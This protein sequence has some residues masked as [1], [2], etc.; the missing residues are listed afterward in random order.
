MSNVNLKNFVETGYKKYS[1]YNLQF[2]SIPH[3][4]DGLKTSQRKILYV[5][6]SRSK[7]FVKVASLAGATI[8]KANYHH[9]NV[10]LEDAIS[11]MAKDYTGSNN[12]PL[13]LGEGN[14]G[15]IFDG[16]FSSARYVSVKNS[17][18]MSKIFLKEDE[19]ILLPSD[20]VE[21]PEPLFYVPVIPWVLINGIKGIAVGY[22][23]DILSY[24]VIDI[25]K[26]LNCL[27]N[28]QPMNEMV[29]YYK[30]YQGQIV[31]DENK[32]VM[33]GAFDKIN[34]TTLEI[35]QLPISYSRESYEEYLIKL[36][37]KDIIKDYK[38]E[39][40]GDQW[41]ITIKTTR[42][43]LSQTDEKIYVDLGLKENLNENINVIYENKV[44]H[45]DS[46]LDL[47]KDFYEIRLTFYEK[48]KKYILS[49]YVNDILKWLIRLSMNKF[50][51]DKK[52]VSFKKNDI[53]EYVLSLKDSFKKIFKDNIG[54]DIKNLDEIMEDMV[55]LNIV[56]LR[57]LDITDDKIQEMNDKIKDMFSQ[58]N[59]L[60]NLTLNDLFQKDLIEFLQNHQKG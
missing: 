9:G 43:F 53:I 55:V 38:N 8:D 47:I 29:P 49:Q 18:M 7:E 19:P 44:L 39:S 32:W 10:S 37:D 4:I 13:F 28:N 56:S 40:F 20:D 58:Y 54:I 6:M 30:G 48:R 31:K 11:L 5:S 57:V 1:L 23:T 59:D 52:Q 15:N 34:S 27:M 26:N 50:V 42:E 33:Y 14:F 16:T 35:T 24:N 17:P 2:R 21:N 60:N 41:K 45:Y 46:P 12:I 3:L 25:I 51:K 36:I 22:A